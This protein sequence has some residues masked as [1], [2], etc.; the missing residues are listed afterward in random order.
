M[1]LRIEKWLERINLN[2][3]TESLFTDSIK[4]YKA[5]AY[6][7][8]LLF[9]YLGLLTILKE[10][11]GAAERPAN[12]PEGQWRQMREDLLNE[13]KWERAV[14]DATQQTGNADANR[15][16]DPVFA[17]QETIRTEIKNWK[18]YRNACAHAKGSEISSFHVEAFW[19]FL[20]NNLSKITV[21]GGMHTL[22][23]K[24]E[25][26]YDPDRNAIGEDIAP[27]IEQ[28]SS[29]VDLKDLPEFW[30]S[31]LRIV[32][33]AP[34]AWL[35]DWLSIFINKVLAL[36]DQYL[37]ETLIAYLKHPQREPLLLKYL[38][39]APSFIS[40]LGYTSEEVR[41]FWRTKLRR[42]N[43]MLAV[44]AAILASSLIP[45]DQLEEA[46]KLV[47]TGLKEYTDKPG[48]HFALQNGGFGI[49]IEWLA[50]E[51][52]KI[53]D[54][55]WAH[56]RYQLLSSFIEKYPLTELIV[57]RL[58][59]IYSTKTHLRLGRSLEVLFRRDAKKKTEFTTIVQA[60]GWILPEFLPS[61]AE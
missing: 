60:K 24:I 27:L 7:A 14:F 10:R 12:Y 36:Q 48:E 46:N 45:D 37:D 18:N 13:D 8:A 16:K 47:V 31:A 53:D 28:I 32:A 2:R 43:N 57:E 44:Y 22:L 15:L 30:N 33:R 55:Q 49:T 40:R 61:L 17:V 35:H 42:C 56:D 41:E 39:H 38:A 6:R 20:E 1:R 58:C 11:I 23:N 21:E 4:C 54:W 51:Q 9:S 3:G 50:F 59:D 25:R 29:T 52:R 5:E 26:H 34:D 19:S